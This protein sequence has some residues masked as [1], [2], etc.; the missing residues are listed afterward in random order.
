[1]KEFNYKLNDAGNPL[2]LKQYIY[3]IG[4]YHFNWHQAIEVLVV[5]NGAVEVCTNGSCKVLET[6]DVIIINP[7]SGHA[8]LAQEPDSIAL[9]LHIDPTFL[10]K[11]YK[12][13]ELL[14]FE[15]CSTSETRNY[16]PF[17][18]IRLYL[19]EMILSQKNNTPEYKLLFESKLYSLIHT[20][21]QYFPPKIIHSEDLALNQ[22]KKIAVEKMVKYIDNNYEKKI[23]LNTLAKECG[24]NGNYVSQLFKTSVGINFYDYLT[25]IRLREAT[26]DLSQTEQKILDIALANG[27]SDIKSFNV[28]FKNNFGKSP[29]EYRKMLNKEIAKVDVSFKKQFMPIDDVLVNNKLN[30]YISLTNSTYMNRAEKDNISDLKKSHKLKKQIEHLSDKFK[31][32]A[33][34]MDEIVV[35]LDNYEKDV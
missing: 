31:D 26:R 13:A 19:S 6:D 17:N 5:L 18:L 3:R 7:N 24:Y 25:R 29:T 35:D 21:V 32:L 28:S 16:T 23:T 14:S 33:G 27:F 11:Y 15:L 30:E 8:T 2:S 4:S 1:M 12:N 10:N 9:L 22:N 34:Q 20:I